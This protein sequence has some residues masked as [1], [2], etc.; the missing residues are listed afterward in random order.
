MQTQFDQNKRVI[1]IH[2]LTA[3]C[4]RISGVCHRFAV[5][6]VTRSR[7]HVS[8]SNPDEYGNENPMVAVFPCYPAGWDTT[9]VILDITRIIN[10]TWDGEGWQAFQPLLDCPTL[11]A[12][13]DNGQ[14][15]NWQSHAELIAAGRTA[16]NNP[17][18]CTRCDVNRS[19]EESC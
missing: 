6:K 7:V 19:E 2:N 4:D 10:D 9:A 12:D 1:S 17:D 13:L 14:F 5:D 18:T 3:M 8:Y 16:A 11:W 15:H